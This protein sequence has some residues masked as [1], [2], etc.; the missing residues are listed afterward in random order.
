MTKK[1]SNALIKK[2]EGMVSKYEAQK[3]QRQVIIS[4]RRKFGT[5]QAAS[6]QCHRYG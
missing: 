6:V 1:K 2:L 5:R 3:L 4:G